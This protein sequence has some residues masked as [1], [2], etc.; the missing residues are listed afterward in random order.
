MILQAFEDYRR[1]EILDFDD[2]L[3]GFASDFD[4]GGR[5]LVSE[6]AD[7]LWVG[8][9]FNGFDFVDGVFAFAEPVP[10]VDPGFRGQFTAEAN[11]HDRAVLVR[12]GF[13]FPF[14]FF[15]IERRQRMAER[16]DLHQRAAARAV[17][18]R[19]GARPLD[20]DVFAGEVD[21]FVVLNLQVVV[22]DSKSEEPELRRLRRFVRGFLVA[23]EQLFLPSDAV[24]LASGV[25]LLGDDPAQ[26]FDRGLNRPLVDV[27]A[28]PPPPQFLRHR[29]R[30]ARTK[31][32]I[33]HEIAW[34]RRCRDD[35]FRESER[36]LRGI[37]HDL[38]GLIVNRLDVVPNVLRRGSSLLDF[39]KVSFEA[40][41]SIAIFGQ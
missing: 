19:V 23:V 5:G 8:A 25:D 37:V 21:C 36:L 33:E 12:T 39:I 7:V 17:E 29:R 40:W 10:V 16:D 18:E 22:I 2:E 14:E 30:R 9:E 32:A 35:P 1:D 27:T 31:K 6:E 13:E 28:N 24:G 26:P 41:H 34:V 11:E 20:A 38:R 15:Q 4:A 3:L